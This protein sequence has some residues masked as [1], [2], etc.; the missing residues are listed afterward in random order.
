MKKDGNPVGKGVVPLRHKRYKRYKRYKGV[1]MEKSYGGI[2][3][4]MPT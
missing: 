4:T 2:Y 1:G 3:L